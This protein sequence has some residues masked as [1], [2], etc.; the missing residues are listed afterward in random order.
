MIKNNDGDY[1][2]LIANNNEIVKLILKHNKN[3]N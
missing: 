1:P 2:L 3:Y